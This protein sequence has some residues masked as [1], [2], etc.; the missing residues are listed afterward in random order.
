MN[1]AENGD[2]ADLGAAMPISFIPTGMGRSL[3]NVIQLGEYTTDESFTHMGVAPDFACGDPI[4]LPPEIENDPSNV[5]TDN[6]TFV[7]RGSDGNSPGYYLAIYRVDDGNGGKCGFLEAY[8]TWLHVNSFYP[9]SF[10]NFV[11]SVLAAHPSVNLQFGN[12]QVNTYVTWSG[13]VIDFTISPLTQIVGTQALNPP[14][15]ANTSFAAGTVI[16]SAQGSG[17]VVISNPSLRTS[18]TLDLR[19]MWHPVRIS[20]TGQVE[21]GGQEVWVNFNYGS[22]AGDFGQPYRTLQAAT[23]A[24]DSPYPATTFKIMAGTEHESITIN[25]PVTLTAVGGPVTIYGQ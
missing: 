8:D 15:P 2:P 1:K 25:K 21:Y 16:N 19:D 12:N 23:N 3:S 10:D 14:P 20:E 9:I 22:N 4:Y 7:N 18:V 5:Q 13:D 24:F 17:L 6:W 11:S